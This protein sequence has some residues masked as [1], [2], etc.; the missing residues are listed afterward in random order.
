MIRSRHISTN[1]LPFVDLDQANP[2]T[3]PHAPITVRAVMTI[4]GDGQLSRARE[5]SSRPA[6]PRLEVG[7]LAAKDGCRAGFHDVDRRP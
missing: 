7:I 1:C 4:A 6:A 5:F 2:V 3:G